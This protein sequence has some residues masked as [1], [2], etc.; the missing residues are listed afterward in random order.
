MSMNELTLTIY[1]KRD[2]I[3]VLYIMMTYR[4]KCVIWVY[5]MTNIIYDD[6]FW[7]VVMLYKQWNDGYK[8]IYYYM[9]ISCILYILS[10]I[11]LVFVCVCIKLCAIIF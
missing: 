2:S 11:H 5:N 3:I 1:F 7:Y 4:A 9:D 10:Y 8:S 6:K